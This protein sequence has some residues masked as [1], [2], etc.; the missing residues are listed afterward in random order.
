VFR[1]RALYYT[2]TLITNECTKSFFIC[3]NTLLHGSTLLVHLQGELSVVITLRLHYTVERECAVDCVLRCFWRREFSVV[4][5]CTLPDD[6]PAGSKH[7]GVC[8]NRW[9]KLFV[10]SL[11]I[12][13]FCNCKMLLRELGSDGRFGTEV[14][15]KLK[16]KDTL[17]QRAWQF[18]RPTLHRLSRL[19]VTSNKP[20]PPACPCY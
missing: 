18:Y 10:H 9:K 11:V 7:V 14:V 19:Y 13:V 2:K 15:W 16:W 12:S 4:S 3:C 17:A 5:A 6:D 20:C 8:Y 1:V